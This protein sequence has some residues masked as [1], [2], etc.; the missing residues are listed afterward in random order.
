MSYIP[1]MPPDVMLELPENVGQEIGF[2]MWGSGYL[3][4]LNEMK[5][6]I[7]EG[8][9]ADLQAIYEHAYERG[10]RDLKLK[11][12]IYQRHGKPKQEEIPAQEE[13]TLT[14]R[15]EA[16]LYLRNMA[17]GLRQNPAQVGIVIVGSVVSAAAGGAAL[18]VTLKIGGNR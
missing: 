3:D 8:E 12:Q 2:E 6:V 17:E 16:R 9:A 5:Y 13:K 7:F 14:P 1:A 15:E 10:T 18:G 4:G 11:T